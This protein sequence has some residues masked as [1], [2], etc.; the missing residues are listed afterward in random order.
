MTWPPQV[1]GCQGEGSCWLLFLLQLVCWRCWGAQL[2]G[3]LT[4]TGEVHKPYDLASLKFV[5]VK[6]RGLVHLRLLEV[7][8]L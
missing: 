3:P 8:A 6:V 4:S 1:C 2:Q 5:A 7:V